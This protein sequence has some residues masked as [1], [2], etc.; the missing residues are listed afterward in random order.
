M[1]TEHV[2]NYEK[3]RK[4]NRRKPILQQRDTASQTMRQQ[5]LDKAKLGSTIAEQRM[6]TQYTGNKIQ[7]MLALMMA[8][9]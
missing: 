8:K 7:T 4:G 1:S 5:H 9:T 2:N 6:N 3:A